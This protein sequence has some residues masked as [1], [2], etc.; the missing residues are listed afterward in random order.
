MVILCPPWV[1]IMGYN[2]EW[3]NWKSSQLTSSSCF[4][5]F[6]GKNHSWESALARLLFFKLTTVLIFCFCRCKTCFERFCYQGH[7]QSMYEKCYPWTQEFHTWWS[8]RSSHESYDQCMMR[9]SH[10]MMYFILYEIF[11][12]EGP[13]KWGQR[14]HFVLF[15]LKYFIK[16]E[17]HHIICIAWL[18]MIIDSWYDCGDHVWN[19]CVHG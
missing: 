12:I 2:Q 4:V 6:Y 7:E 11:Q 13:E 16:Y 18:F 3:I 15:Y 17:I 8:P 1:L 9:N 14:C 10:T 5:T 19:S